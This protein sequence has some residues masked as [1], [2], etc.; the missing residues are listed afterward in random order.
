MLDL[1]NN[2]FQTIGSDSQYIMSNVAIAAA[3]T[4]YARIHMIP[5]KINPNTLYTDTDSIFTIKPLDPRDV[6][7]RQI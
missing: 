5:F 1:L 7:K 4:S 3:V 6:Y 2:E